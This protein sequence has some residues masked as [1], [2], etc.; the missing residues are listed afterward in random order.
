FD[1]RKLGATG[2]KVSCL[3]LGTAVTFGGQISDEVRFSMVCISISLSRKN[4]SKVICY[5]L[6][7]YK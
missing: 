1:F 3:G 7:G 5:A 4:Q 2:L 6:Y